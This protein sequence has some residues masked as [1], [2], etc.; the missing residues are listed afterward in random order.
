MIILAA[1]TFFE[2]H[3]KVAELGQA[4]QMLVPIVGN[5][6][7]LVFGIAL[8]AAG[9]SSSITAG[10]AGGTIFAGMFGETYDIKDL[11]TKLG[12]SSILTASLLVI[13]FISD[14]FQGLIYSQMLLSIQLPITVFLQIYLT[15]SEKVMGKY[16]NS[17]LD[18]TALILISLA[19]CILYFMLFLSYFKTT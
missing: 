14:P 7:A 4:Q 11:H 5:F 9:I 19:L 10:M 1:T 12:V 13:F 2:N 6:A 8:L 18:S 3:I 17:L 15:S 16:K